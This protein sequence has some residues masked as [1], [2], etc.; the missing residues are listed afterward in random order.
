MNQVPLRLLF[1]LRGSPSYFSGMPDGGHA[2]L[3][4]FGRT[5][6]CVGPFFLPPRLAW[7]YGSTRRCF[8]CSAGE[9]AR[10]GRRSG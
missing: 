2:R 9:E 10:L 3:H 6:M 4:R 8:A 1:L 5:A 7:C